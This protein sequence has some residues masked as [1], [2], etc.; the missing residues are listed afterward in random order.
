[1]IKEKIFRACMKC[2]S[3]NLTL[4]QTAWKIRAG[5]LKEAKNSLKN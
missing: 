3:T 2:G 4:P 5:V 1:M